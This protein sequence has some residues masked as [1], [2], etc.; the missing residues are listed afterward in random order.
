MGAGLGLWVTLRLPEIW[1]L[2]SL[3]ALNAWVAY[4]YG[5]NVTHHTRPGMSPGLF[6]GPV[7]FASGLLGIGGGTMLVPLLRRFVALRH[8]VGTSAVCG[9]VMALGAVALNSALEPDWASRLSD[10]YIVLIAV[11]SG[12]LLALP[13]TSGWSARMHERLDEHILR[14]ILKSIFAAI[15]TS[16]LIAALL[17]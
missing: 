1:I 5:R 8:A 16:M 2:L 14:L 9:M 10:Q 17:S 13:L 11:W 12:V 3:A 7:G 4:D 15:S 6:S